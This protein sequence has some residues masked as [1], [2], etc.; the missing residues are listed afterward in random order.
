[1]GPLNV[2]PSIETMSFTSWTKKNIQRD[3]VKLIR[4]TESLCESSV[5]EQVNQVNSAHLWV[6]NTQVWTAHTLDCFIFSYCNKKVWLQQIIFIY[7]NTDAELKV[8]LFKQPSILQEID[9]YLEP[10]EHVLKTGHKWA[11]ILGFYFAVL[12]HEH[13]AVDRKGEERARAG[14][15]S[16]GM[17]LNK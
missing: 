2:H 8:C 14:L 15:K 6:L 17:T 11:R 9:N 5:W 16:E 4:F 1:M 12:I 13:P 3:G 10:F 7:Y